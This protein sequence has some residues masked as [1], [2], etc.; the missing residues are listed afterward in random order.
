MADKN[1]KIAEEVLTAVGGKENIV[2]V[3]HCMTPLFTAIHF[4]SNG[5]VCFNLSGCDH[6]ARK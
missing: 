6:I 5:F 4:G 1:R 3:T 2:S